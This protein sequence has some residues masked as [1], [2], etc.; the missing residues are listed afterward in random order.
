MSGSAAMRGGASRQTPSPRLVQTPWPRPAPKGCEP[1]WGRPRSLASRAEGRRSERD[2]PQTWQRGRGSYGTATAGFEP[3]ARGE[4]F[5][6]RRS[7][8]AGRQRELPGGHGGEQQ[9]GSGGFGEPVFT[10]TELWLIEGPHT[11]RGPKGY[12]RSDERLQEQVCERLERHGQIDASEIEVTVENGVVTLEGQVDDRR[13]KRLAEECAE[14]VYGVQDVMN[15]LRVDAGF[16]QRL[17]GG[18]E[19]GEQGGKEP[20]TR[21]PAGRG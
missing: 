4:R 6:P 12:Q 5:G 9:F 17:F 8:E 18:G 16:F 20:A 1:R 7:G 3:E 10:Y 14:S 21:R 13:T 15:R 19:K 11:G 2:D